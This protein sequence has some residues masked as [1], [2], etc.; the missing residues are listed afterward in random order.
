[1]AWLV[2]LAGEDVPGERLN[3][4][5][6]TQAELKTYDVFLAHGSG[7]KPAVRELYDKLTQ[8]GFSVFLDIEEIAPGL[9]WRPALEDGLRASRSLAYCLGAAGPGP[10]TE[11]ELSVGLTRNRDDS[12]FAVIPVW[13]RGA[14][15]RRM[16]DESSFLSQ[17]EVVDLREGA[18]QALLLRGWWRS[19][20]GSEPAATSSDLPHAFPWVRSKTGSSV[21]RSDSLARYDPISLAGS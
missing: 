14:T 11:L 3:M 9:P 10:W 2:L 17:F 4:E 16:A 12:S 21:S 6:G 15:H 20:G 19:Y 1:M 8:A 18:P 13:L 5:Q 7:D